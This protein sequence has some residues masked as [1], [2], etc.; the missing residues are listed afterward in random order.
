MNR[1]FPVFNLAMTI[2]PKYADAYYW[3]ARS[4]EALGQK[5]EALSAV[6]PQLVAQ[7]KW[8]ANMCFQMA[9]VYSIL[10]EKKEML[11]WIDLG[12]KKGFMNYPV[13]ASFDPV[14]E[15]FHSDPDFQQLL[16]EMKVKRRQLDV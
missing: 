16:E 12:M 7:A 2:S 11:Y 4:Q 9:T 3:M 14:F 8:S 6:N 1:L 5:E 15:P 13:Y 10:K